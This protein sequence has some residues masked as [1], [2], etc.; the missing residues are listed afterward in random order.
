MIVADYVSI[1]LLAGIVMFCLWR[2][3]V[4][5]KRVESLEGWIEIFQSHLRM[6]DALVEHTVNKLVL[7]MAE[8]FKK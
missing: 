5:E 7:P 3:S 4:L 1:A 6:T 2:I 8:R